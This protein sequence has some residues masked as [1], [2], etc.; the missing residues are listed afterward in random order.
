MLITSSP[1]LRSVV[2]VLLPWQ[3]PLKY[4]KTVSPSFLSQL[5]HLFYRQ[6]EHNSSGPS[7]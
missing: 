1:V 6:N 4:V 7:V 5:S 3:L 2:Y